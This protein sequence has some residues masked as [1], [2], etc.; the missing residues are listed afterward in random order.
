MSSNSAAAVHMA[1]HHT[2]GMPIDPWLP[3]AAAQHPERVALEAPEGALTY[4]QLLEAARI[5]VA[6]GSRV[7]LALAPG[8]DFAVALHACLLARAAAMPVDP[9]L[10][11][12]EQQAL[13]ASADRVVDGALGRRGG[14][15]PVAPAESDI[16]LVVHT[17]GTTAA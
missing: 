14:A 3:R 4:A 6:P 5:D 9:R 11:A 1:A 10:G 12:T 15:R 7:A 2:S 16:A 13:L 17:S 8:L